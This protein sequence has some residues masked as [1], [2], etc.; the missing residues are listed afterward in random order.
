MTQLVAVNGISLVVNSQYC[1]K[2][3]TFVDRVPAT[4][5]IQVQPNLVLGIRKKAIRI[6]INPP[7]RDASV[8]QFECTLATADGLDRERVRY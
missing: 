3:K 6:P 8:T 5:V 2:R 1:L 4:V 7:D